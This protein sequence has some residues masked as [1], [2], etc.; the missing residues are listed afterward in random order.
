M[1]NVNC[2]NSG[3]SSIIVYRMKQTYSSIECVKCRSD[4]WNNRSHKLTDL[5]Y[6]RCTGSCEDE[7]SRQAFNSWCSSIG[8]LFVFQH[9]N[10]FVTKRK[11]YECKT[12]NSL[13]IINTVLEP[14]ECGILEPINMFSRIL[15]EYLKSIDK[16]LSAV[17]MYA[18]FYALRKQSK[19]SC[20]FQWQMSNTKFMHWLL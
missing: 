15:F 1:S 11:S 16:Q 20:Y 17:C 6:E 7:M 10:I 18:I 12:K 5:N 13:V 8:C 2:W 14:N 3:W 4:Y 9:I 19:Y